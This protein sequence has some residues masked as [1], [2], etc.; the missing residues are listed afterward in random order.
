MNSSEKVEP[1][2]M[3]APSYKWY[4]LFVLTGVYVFNFIDRQILVIIQ[5]QSPQSTLEVTRQANEIRFENRGNTN[6]LLSDG[7]QCASDDP[8]N[9]TDLPSH[10]VYAG[11]SWSLELPH[12]APLSYSVRDFEGIRNEVFP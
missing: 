4:V 5:P 3:H 8:E 6:V 7:R 12:D 10:R 2:Q 9:C 1:R 11:T